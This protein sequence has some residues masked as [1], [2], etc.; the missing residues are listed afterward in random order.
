MNGGK[1]TK[2]LNEKQEFDW[3]LL[4]FACLFE[5]DIM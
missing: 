5:W 3:L 2:W 1:M 4:F